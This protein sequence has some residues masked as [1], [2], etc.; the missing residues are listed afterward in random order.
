MIFQI[1]L[2]ED[3]HSDAILVE[4]A[5]DEIDAECEVRVSVNGDDAIRSLSTG[6]RPHLIFL[7]LNLAGSSGMDVLNAIRKSSDSVLRV[8]PV[9]LLTNSK[10]DDDIF[11]AYENGC[12]A[13]MTKPLGYDRVTEAVDAASKFWLM[14]ASLP[15]RVPKSSPPD[16]K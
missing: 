1:M 8:T 15:R 10:R 11:D 7:D 5:F 14:H 13:Y 2:V 16:S 4:E 9:I 6:Y 3:S 12:N